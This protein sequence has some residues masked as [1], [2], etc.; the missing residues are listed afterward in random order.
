MCL[1]A[2]AKAQ[3]EAAR[4]DYKYRIEQR[5]QDWMQQLSL[6]GAE[7]VQ[8]EVGINR[9]G[10]R[11][12]DQYAKIQQQQT[13]AISQAYRAEETDLIKFLQNNQ[14]DK[15][16]A[17]GQTGRSIARQGVLDVGALLRERAKRNYVLTTNEYKMKEQFK[18][19]REQQK[20][21]DEQLF[22]KVRYIKQPGLEPPQPVMQSVGAAMFMDALG[23]AGSVAGIYGGFK[24]D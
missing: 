14:Y 4:R 24:N 3:N 7:R 17:S 1:G 23:I 16:L 8:Y 21:T 9:S 5:E 12:Q 20:L 2:S 18:D 6:A 13:E 22:N 15:S 11:T 19:I 10:L